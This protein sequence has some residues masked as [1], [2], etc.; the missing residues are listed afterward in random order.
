MSHPTVQAYETR[1]STGSPAL[2]FSSSQGAHFID[3][4]ELP[5]HKW[6]DILSVACLPIPPLGYVVSSGPGRSRTATVRRPLG[7][8]QLGSPMHADPRSD[9]GGI[10][11]RDFQ[12]ESVATTTTSPLGHVL[13][14]RVGVEPTNSHEGLSFVALPVCVPRHFK[15][16]LGMPIAESSSSNPQSD[17]C[18]PQLRASPMGFEPTASTLTGWRALLAA[19]RGLCFLQWLRW[20]SNPQ[21]PWF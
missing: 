15:S 2:L 13:V 11:T 5:R 16:D 20:D 3:A 17:F 10:R 8:S 6:Y 1:L 4:G 12:G 18:I 14:A 7:Y 9:P 21:H 19:P